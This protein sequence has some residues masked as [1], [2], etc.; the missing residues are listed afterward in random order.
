MLRA[1]QCFC[2]HT[3]PKFKAKHHEVQFSSKPTIRHALGYP[4][5]CSAVPLGN[6]SERG[7]MRQDWIEY[8]GTCGDRSSTQDGFAIQKG[9]PNG[10]E[11]G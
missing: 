5:E 8:S 1:R 11:T 10:M 6:N 7:G 2:G 9:Y 3:R 4:H